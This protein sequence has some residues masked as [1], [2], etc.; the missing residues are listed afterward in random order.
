MSNS[1]G[2]WHRERDEVWVR[3]ELVLFS[4]FCFIEGGRESGTMLE[5]TISNVPLGEDSSVWTCKMCG[6][7]DVYWLLMYSEQF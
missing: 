5:T 4:L 7:F 2:A 1:T 6:P 3:V